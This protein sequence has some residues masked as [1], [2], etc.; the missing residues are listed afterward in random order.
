[1][2]FSR[3][4]YWSGLPL[5]SPTCTH[6]HTHTYIYIYTHIYIYKPYLKLQERSITTRKFLRFFDVTFCFPWTGVTRE[7]LCAPCFY[8]SAKQLASLNISRQLPNEML[9]SPESHFA[10]KTLSDPLKLTKVFLVQKTLWY[11]QNKCSDI[12]KIPSKIYTRPIY[13]ISVKTGWPLKNKVVSTKIFPHF[14]NI[15]I[16]QFFQYIMNSQVHFFICFLK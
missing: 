13:R 9:V 1:M 10:Y 5:P 12:L 16:P 2:G 8:K 4:E 11:C 3:Q 7:S 6:T 14:Q 15:F